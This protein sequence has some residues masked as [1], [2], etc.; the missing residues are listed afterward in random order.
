MRLRLGRRNETAGKCDLLPIARQREVGNRVERD[1]LPKAARRVAPA[2]ASNPRH[3]FLRNLPPRSGQFN[4]SSMT[5]RLQRWGER[6][7]GEVKS[8]APRVAS[9][10]EPEPLPGPSDE[11]SGFREVSVESVAPQ[12]PKRPAPSPEPPAATKAVPPPPQPAV[13]ESKTSES[14][15]IAPRS[16]PS[17][18]SDASPPPPRQIPEPPVH[19]IAVGTIADVEPAEPPVKRAPHRVHISPPAVEPAPAKE[20][21]VVRGDRQLDRELERLREWIATPPLEEEPAPPPSSKAE[22]G[23]VDEVITART[24]ERFVFPQPARS[25]EPVPAP[26]PPVEISIGTIIVRAN[27]APAPRPSAPPPAAGLKAFLARRNSGQP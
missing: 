14:T 19:P 13:Y 10:F 22:P 15:P 20:T 6:A 25:R 16:A 1:S 21:P 18:V 4:S 11:V 2:G 24:P 23:V 12:S 17:G 3:R 26:P 9:R 27:P 7:L 8:V 5:N